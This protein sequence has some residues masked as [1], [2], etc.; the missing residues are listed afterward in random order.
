M[1]K[2]LVIED[3]PVVRTNLEAILQLSDYEVVSAEDGQQGLELAQKHMPDL[4]ICDIMMPVLDGHL[5]LN[6]IRKMPATEDIPFI[7][8]TAKADRSDV[9]QGMDLGADDYLIKPFTPE[10]VLAAVEARL[11]RVAHN[12]SAL[13]Q[14]TAPAQREV[15]PLTKLPLE[16]TLAGSNGYLTQAIHKIDSTY[17]FIPFLV[18]GF[19]Q[20]EK[21]NESMGYS[22]GDQVLLRLANRLQ[23][24]KP[25]SSP[26]VQLRGN[27][28]AL[29]L[30]AV[31]HPALALSTAQEILGLIAKPINLGDQ[32]V[33]V[34]ASIG[35]AF[36]P[37]AATLEELRRQA[38]VALHE[39][40]SLGGNLCRT[41]IRKP[42]ER[43]TADN[44]MLSADLLQAWQKRQLKIVYLPR[45]DLQT[46]KLI[47][48][49]VRG[50]WQH[51]TRGL[52]PP[53]KF[54]ALIEESGLSAELGKWF[55]RNAFVKLNQC[56]KQQ[57]NYRV[58]VELPTPLFY[59]ENLEEILVIG[60][61]GAKAKPQ[62]L[63]LE[64]SSDLITPV[65]NPKYVESRLQRLK[66]IG[67][68]LT[69]NDVGLEHI[70]SE[71][72]KE[73]IFD[74]VKLKAK[75]VDGIDT[76]PAAVQTWV[77]LAA[78]HNLRVIAWGTQDN[79]QLKLLKRYKI[80]EAQT[81]L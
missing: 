39:A 54:I 63:E 20:L 50:N 10:E 5:V 11:N 44:L 19:D 60:L 43:E 64:I 69:L 68:G 58:S 35:A 74:K 28:L 47:G 2:I 8:L 51:P 15:D 14:L 13:Q 67:V 80:D 9:R 29:L 53:E 34:T 25:D 65:H 45:I 41:Y 12:Y 23:D 32:S 16:S 24:F 59:A 78:E 17:R 71:F 70:S 3:E 52:I 30:P 38:G 61:Q 7:F 75:L 73:G 49:M 33:L 79:T 6:A 4:I 37:I 48:G 81:A 66:Q 57:V 36:Y 26:L 42:S 55:L 72:L 76:H 46:Q 31:A 21:I 40:K 56:L 77:K 62:N 22:K 1:Q 27:G 18:I